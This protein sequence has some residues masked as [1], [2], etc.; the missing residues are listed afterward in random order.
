MEENVQQT[1]ADGKG[2][3]AE[4]NRALLRKVCHEKQENRD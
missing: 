2:K 4:S 3:S 1:L